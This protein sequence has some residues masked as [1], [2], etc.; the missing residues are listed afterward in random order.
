MGVGARQGYMAETHGLVEALTKKQERLHTAMATGVLWVK[1]E[2]DAF[3]NCCLGQHKI[4]MFRVILPFSALFQM[5][6]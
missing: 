2:I 1:L 6:E 3:T 5:N 4:H